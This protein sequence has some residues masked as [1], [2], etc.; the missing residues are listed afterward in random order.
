MKLTTQNYLKVLKFAVDI[1][2]DKFN[3]RKLGVSRL[4][5]MNDVWD[6]I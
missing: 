5:L 6:E 3:N 1:K 4:H 2:T